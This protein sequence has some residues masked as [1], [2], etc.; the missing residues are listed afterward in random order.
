MP[1]C[2][3][4]H[5]AECC[6]PVPVAVEDRPQGVCAF[7]QSWTLHCKITMTLI[8]LYEFIWNLHVSNFSTACNKNRRLSI[9]RPPLLLSVK[10][11]RSRNLLVSDWNKSTTVNLGTSIQYSE[12]Q[13]TILCLLPHILRLVNWIWKWTGV[14]QHC[15]LTH[16]K[17]SLLLIRCMSATES[18]HYLFKYGIRT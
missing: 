16:C 12:R 8:M 7:V 1:L 13:G 2:Q 17:E 6:V 11:C 15:R 18:G 10:N 3:W 14:A 5:N 4:Q 9:S